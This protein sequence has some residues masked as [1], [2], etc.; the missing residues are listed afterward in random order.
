MCNGAVEYLDAEEE[1][2]AMICMTP[3]DLE[4]YPSRSKAGVCQS[5]TMISDDPEQASQDQDEPDYAHLHSLR[6]SSQHDSGCLRQ[7]HSVPDHNQVSQPCRL[8]HSLLHSPPVTPTNPPWVSKPWVSSSPTLVAAWIPWPT[9]STTRRSLW[10]PLDPWSFCKFRE[11]PAGQNAIVAIACYS[12]YNQ[13]DSVIMNQSSIDRGLFRSLF[14]RSYTDQEKKV[15][16]NVRGSSSR[17]HCVR[18]C[19]GS[20]TAHMTSLTTMVSSHPAVRVS[21][22]DIIIG[23]TAPIDTRQPGARPAH[24]QSTRSATSPRRCEAR[25]MASLTQVILTTNADRLEV[26][27]GSSANDEDPANWR[28]VCLSSRSERHHWYHLSARRHALHDERV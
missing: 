13:E 26:C 17:S 2:T 1:E 25:R 6:N 8:S 4:L 27:Q 3:E 28:Q 21:G 5:M 20:S 7:H 24:K 22:E 12:G 10:R 19:F 18:D 23:K 15:G 16:L 14:Y 11:L 9:F